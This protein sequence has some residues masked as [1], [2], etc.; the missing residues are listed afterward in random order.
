MFIVAGDNDASGGGETSAIESGLLIKKLM[1]NARV[2][3]VIPPRE[4]KDLREWVQK[5]ATPELVVAH[6]MNLPTNYKNV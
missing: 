4:I 6:A 2:L 1:P 5:G 3:T